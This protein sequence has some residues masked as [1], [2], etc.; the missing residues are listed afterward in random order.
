MKSPTRMTLQEQ[1]GVSNVNLRR[2]DT[3]VKNLPGGYQP[4]IRGLS[5]RLAL[6][7]G[8]LENV[9]FSNSNGNLTKEGE[10]NWGIELGASISRQRCSPSRLAVDVV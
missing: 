5:E 2:L 9:H 3:R 10:G 8:C 7:V 6:A 4:K 1:T